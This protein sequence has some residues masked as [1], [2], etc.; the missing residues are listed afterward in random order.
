VPYLALDGVTVP[1]P[2][3]Q[4]NSEAVEVGTVEASFDGT[5]RSS[6]RAYKDRWEI[7]TQWMASA[8][9]ATLE[10]VLVSVPPVAATG[11]LTGSLSVVLTNVRRQHR[12]FADG[13]RIRF[14]FVMLEG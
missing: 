13:E 8:D 3:D 7:P 14:D 1:V 11:T 12:K 4:P 6:V 10:A 9:A 2:V 5:P